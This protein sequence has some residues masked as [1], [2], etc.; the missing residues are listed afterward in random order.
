MHS[1]VRSITSL[2]VAIVEITA[3]ISS[4]NQITVPAE[5]RR[6]GI[7]ASDTIAFVFTEKG[8]IEVQTPRFDLESILGSIPPLPGASPDFEREIEEAT[9]EEIARLARRRS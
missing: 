2:G 5:V 1:I 3:K 7:S 4:K 9:A 6:L 8:T